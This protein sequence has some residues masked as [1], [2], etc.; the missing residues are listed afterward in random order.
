MPGGGTCDSI[1]TPGYD[2]PTKRFVGPFIASMLT[3][4]WIYNGSLDA[5]EK[6]LTLASLCQASEAGVR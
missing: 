2:P 5:A 3:H 6:V 4:V 1:M